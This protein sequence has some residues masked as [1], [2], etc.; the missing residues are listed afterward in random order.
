[1]NDYEDNDIDGLNA[2]RGC[3]NAFLFSIPIWCI[4]IGVVLWRILK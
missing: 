1:M 2:F 4:I 3:L